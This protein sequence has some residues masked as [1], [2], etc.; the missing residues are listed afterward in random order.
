M[1]RTLRD[2]PS[3]SEEWEADRELREDVSI[4]C[5]TQPTS[6]TSIGPHGDDRLNASSDYDVSSIAIARLRG[7]AVSSEGFVFTERNEL[8]RE[9]VDRTDYADRFVNRH[10][11][12]K[13]ELDATPV[14]PSPRRV[15]VLGCQRNLNY[16]HWWVD[17][18]PR[19]WAIRNSAYRDCVLMTAPLTEA[20]QSESLRLLGQSVLPLTR[21]LQRFRE[22]VFVRGLT[23]GSSQALAPQLTEFAQWCRTTLELSPPSEGRRLFVSRRG[24][25]SRR[26]VNEDEVVAA[27]GPDFER[28]V[29]E[30]LSVSEQ[31]SLFS[32]AEV[33]VA[34]HGAGLTNLLFCTRPA[35][36]V[37]LVHEDEPPVVFR[38]LAELLGHR[39]CAVGCIPTEDGGRKAGRRNLRASPAAVAAALAGLERKRTYSS[40]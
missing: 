13:T 4:R 36:V 25:R 23:Y 7:G 31:A 29:A 19:C 35:R 34:P 40:A 32:A 5:V 39:Y 37:E 22:L 26:L 12:L 11:Q 33:V 30:S 14:E 8:V 1:F 21:P 24:A 10:P 9:S 3:E 2:P 28:V 16:F 15:A 18:L 27:L 20:F 38:H 6:V 17:V